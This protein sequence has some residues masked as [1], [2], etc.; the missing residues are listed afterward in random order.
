VWL[1]RRFKIGLL[2][3]P[4]GSIEAFQFKSGRIVARIEAD[5]VMVKQAATTQD[6]CY[7]EVLREASYHIDHVCVEA[8]LDGM[9]IHLVYSPSDNSAKRT[10]LACFH[11]LYADCPSYC[12]RGTNTLALQNQRLPQTF[13]SESDYE[14]SIR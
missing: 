13:L 7:P 2:V 3:L 5:C 11:L 12:S 14:L 4:L 10:F 1:L 9:I 8:E 6:C